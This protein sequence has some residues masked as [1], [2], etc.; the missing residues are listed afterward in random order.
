MTEREEKIIQYR[1]IGLTLQ[2]IGSLLG[3]SR[4]RVHQVLIKHGIRQESI[5]E[6]RQKI[7]Q[8][9]MEKVLLG[10]DLPDL[11]ELEIDPNTYNH[12][13]KDREDRYD[14]VQKFKKLGMTSQQIAKELDVGRKCY[15]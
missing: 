10:I 7:K 5:N 14:Q 6:I 12:Y 2:E 1:F 9:K 4:Q 8:E 15:K 13:N 11:S 3:I